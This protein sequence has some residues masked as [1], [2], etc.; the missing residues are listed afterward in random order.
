MS[1]N[2]WHILRDAKAQR[3]TLA[4]RTPAVFDFCAETV[5][6][7]GSRLRLATQIRQDMWRKLQKLRGF[8]PVV[9]IERR[10][11]K[12]WVRAGG[13]VA[14]RPFPKAS[15]EAAVSDLLANPINRKRWIAHADGQRGAK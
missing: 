11:Q 12:L 7:D 14:G 13:S 2:G 10:D 3:L 6:E 15:A 9:Q 4:R 5:I 1:R 8:S